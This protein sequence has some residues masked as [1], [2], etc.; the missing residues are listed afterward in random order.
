[1]KRIK[2]VLEIG[3][4]VVAF[5]LLTTA[6]VA[7]SSVY[8]EPV[9]SHS[10]PGNTT[11]VT[12]WLDTD[13]G[14]GA[15]NDDILFDI[16]VVNITAATGGNFSD[17]W[18][19]VHYDTFIRIGGW[20]PD[21]LDHTGHLKLAD[22]T[23]E[24]QNPGTCTLYHTTNAVGHYNGTPVSATWANGT[25]TCADLQQCLGTCCNDL[26]CTDPFA[27]NVNCSSCINQSKYWHPNKDSACFWSS[28]PSD[29]CL[30][31]CPHCSDGS[32][33]DHDG[34]TDFPSDEECTCGLDPSEV[35]PMAPIP[36][37]SSWI[38]LSIGLCALVLVVRWQ[39]KK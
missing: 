37:V 11:T 34:N 32:D 27:T 7:T 36:E 12:L 39:R 2:I 5:S 15:F 4:L 38:L 14:V 26:D 3:F 10:D 17:Q 13:E 18:T 21:S 25:F 8:F 9:S 6:A 30:S 29:L 23:L 28:S 1:M 24:A 33:N 22:L 35:N 19:F 20:S 31:D 16:A